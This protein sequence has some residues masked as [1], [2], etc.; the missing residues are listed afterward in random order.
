MKSPLPTRSRLPDVSRGSLQTHQ[1]TLS[2]QSGRRG[3]NPRPSRWQ[4]DALPLSYSR[5]VRIPDHIAH[6][7]RGETSGFPSWRSPAIVMPWRDRYSPLPRRN[8]IGELS[9]FEVGRGNGVFPSYQPSLSLKVSLPAAYPFPERLAKFS[10]RVC[11]FIYG[12]G[13]SF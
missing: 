1:S 7:P 9:V 4:R 12:F 13:C 8:T 10:R 5:V 6:S 2:K 3:L 11:L